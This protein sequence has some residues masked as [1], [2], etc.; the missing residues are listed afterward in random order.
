MW[1]ILNREYKAIN[2]IIDVI[3][4]SGTHT[5]ANRAGM[6]PRENKPGRMPKAN[7]AKKRCL[8]RT[9]LPLVNRAKLLRNPM[10]A[11]ITPQISSV[12]EKKLLS[13]LT[14]VGEWG[15]FSTFFSTSD[16]VTETR[17]PELQKPAWGPQQVLFKVSAH[18]RGLQLASWGQLTS[19][20]ILPHAA[21][22]E[23]PEA[24]QI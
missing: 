4:T 9:G 3:H 8:A 17:A 16:A 7:R 11:M 13:S 22:H 20:Q 14:W 19:L 2:H 21:V 23:A 24:H 15:E 10:K 5:H 12:Y 18:T 1:S 6:L